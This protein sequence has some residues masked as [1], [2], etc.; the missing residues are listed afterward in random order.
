MN[1]FYCKFK[2]FKRSRLDVFPLYAIV[3]C[4]LEL[5]S[6]SVKKY[7]SMYCYKRQ[8]VF[9]VFNSIFLRYQSLINT[10]GEKKI[11]KIWESNLCLSENRFNKNVVDN[12]NYMCH[13]MCTRGFRFINKILVIRENAQNFTHSQIS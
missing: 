13:I 1:C 3:K 10:I 12:D 7:F 11:H 5:I 6:I 4:Y 8:R 9:A 2:C